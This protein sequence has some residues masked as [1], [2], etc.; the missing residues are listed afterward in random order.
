MTDKY[1]IS[2]QRYPSPCGMLMLGSF[3]DR[4]CLCDWQVERHS[5]LVKRRLKRM[6]SAEFEEAP[7]EITRCAAAQLDEYFAGKRR[8]FDVPLRF[9]GTDFQ[10]R[11]WEELL[12]IPYGVTISYGELARRLD[13]PSAVRAVANANGANAM[14]I[15]VP[16]HRIIGTDHSLTGYAG[17]LQAKRMLLELEGV[18]L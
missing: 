5:D 18:C 10:K 9:A 13:R 8:A 14:S 2:V 4:L 17:G 11:V 16:C 6:L 12:H 15:F 1:I 7:S 3:G